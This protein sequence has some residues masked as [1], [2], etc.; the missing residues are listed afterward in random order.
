M[1]FLLLTFEGKVRN[2]QRLSYLPQGPS[3]LLTIGSY[4][5]NSQQNIEIVQIL[6]QMHTKILTFL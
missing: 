1:L 3:E 4:D 2:G 6:F 5:I